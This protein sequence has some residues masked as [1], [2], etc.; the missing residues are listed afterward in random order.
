M[1]SADQRVGMLEAIVSQEIHCP[2]NKT[3]KLI[4]KYSKIKI[5]LGH[6]M[7]TRLQVSIMI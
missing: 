1:S 4:W 2:G 6:C 7:F 5:Y 3:K